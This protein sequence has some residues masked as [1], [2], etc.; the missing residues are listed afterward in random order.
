MGSTHLQV[1]LQINYLYQLQHKTI[2]AVSFSDKEYEP[3]TTRPSAE[4]LLSDHEDSNV[5]EDDTPAESSNVLA[6]ATETS[7]QGPALGPDLFVQA[8]VKAYT[9]WLER[10]I[11]N[12]PIGQRIRSVAEQGN[13]SRTTNRRPPSKVLIAAA[14]PPLVEDH[15]LNRIPEKYVERLEE[16]HEKT[17]KAMGRTPSDLGDHSRTPWTR[18]G[19]ATPVEVGLSTLTVSD[20]LEPPSPKSSSSSRSD[21]SRVS[22][23]FEAVQ[24]S[25]STITTASSIAESETT[26]AKP[27]S[28]TSKTSIDSLLTHRTPLCT[29]PTRV[30][31]TDLF[32][33]LV[34]EFCD[35][36]SDVL[37]FI[38][39]SP[40]MRQSETYQSQH[41]EVDRATWAC[42]VDPTNI[43][44]V[45]E[46]T[47]PLW[48]EALKGAGVPTDG[49][50]LNEDAEETFK[51]YELDKRRRTEK[52]DHE[53]SEEAEATRLSKDRAG[54]LRD[55]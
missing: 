13:S 12:G 53:W 8:V 3:I 52:R 36:H 28:T 29:L 33:K 19:A 41:G 7:L 11:V 45:W 49:F 10:E 1:D 27:T 2:S 21:S 14:L 34:S 50:E 35:T 20:S 23:A 32:N 40:Q 48:L 38:D 43:H 37:A 4:T 55:E 44:P 54:K 25:Q 24:S 31:M 42:P 46:P 15:V 17:A 5:T 9:T 18:S 51:A 26:S 16:E 22:S 39:I 30:R 47:L 6:D